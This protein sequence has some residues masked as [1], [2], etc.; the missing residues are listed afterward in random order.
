MLRPGEALKLTR[1]DVLL[2][3]DLMTNRPSCFLRVRDPKNR[4][5]AA[6][7]EHVRI[8]DCMVAD[9]LEVWLPRLQPSQ[10]LFAFNASQMRKYHDHLVSFF[11]L[12]ALEGTGITPASHR[13]GGATLSFERTGKL[14]LTRWRGRWSSTSRT[15]EIYIREVAAASVLPTVDARHRALVLWLHGQLFLYGKT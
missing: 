5:I 10:R 2:P 9:R 3:V 15:L 14:E 6:R 1:A 13:G 11:G 4:R 7:R 8:D 12:P